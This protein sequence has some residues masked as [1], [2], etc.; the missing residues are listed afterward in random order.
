MALFARPVSE[1]LAGKLVAVPKNRN[2]GVS[3]CQP[4]FFRQATLDYGWLSKQ[5]LV[6]G[7]GSSLTRCRHSARL[8]CRKPCEDAVSA[9]NQPYAALR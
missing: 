1:N 9:A 8:S 5:T 4:N 3:Q 6:A 2:S 7:T